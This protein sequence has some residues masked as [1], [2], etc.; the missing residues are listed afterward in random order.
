MVSPT[1]GPQAF[2]KSAEL[3]F[4]VRLKKGLTVGRRTKKQRRPKRSVNRPET[5]QNIVWQAIN[6]MPTQLM[7]G[8]GPTNTN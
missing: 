8:E 3:D 6:D 2:C 5:M 4:E 1:S 7:Y